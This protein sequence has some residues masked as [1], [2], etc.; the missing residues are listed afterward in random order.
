MFIQPH[1]IYFSNLN[2]LTSITRI[3]Y[4]ILNFLYFLQIFLLP[5]F[6]SKN[7]QLGILIKI[8]QEIL[9]SLILNAALTY[10][11]HRNIVDQIVYDLGSIDRPYI[12]RYHLQIYGRIRKYRYDS[13]LVNFQ[14]FKYCHQNQLFLQLNYLYFFLLKYYLA[15]SRNDSTLIY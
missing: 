5:A 3:N 1:R 12:H 7:I 14:I 15:S 2:F 13:L 10:F 11:Y 9:P 8:H 6:Q 4:I